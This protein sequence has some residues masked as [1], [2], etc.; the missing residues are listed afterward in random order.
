MIFF[1]M[2]RKGTL[3][4]KSG[5]YR[6]GQTVVEPDTSPLPFC[7]ENGK[8]KPGKEC[9]PEVTA[10][11]DA[12]AKKPELLFKKSRPWIILIDAAVILAAIAMT[13]WMG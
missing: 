12:G 6:E 13:V 11:T 9:R 3:F 10:K 8:L 4:R 7:A 1:E 2:A 5:P